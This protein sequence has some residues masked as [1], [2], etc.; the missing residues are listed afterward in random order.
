MKEDVLKYYS[1]MP[2]VFVKEMDLTQNAN[3]Q[4][5]V[6]IA[7]LN[8]KPAVA[9]FRGTAL[10]TLTSDCLSITSLFSKRIAQGDKLSCFPSAF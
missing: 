4:Y 9:L 7:M 2:D 5:T 10:W 3:I 6:S 1:Q 8:Y